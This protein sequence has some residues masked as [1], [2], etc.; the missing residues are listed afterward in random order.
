MAE[1][2]SASILALLGGCA[3]TAHPD[4]TGVWQVADPELVKRP[5]VYATEADYMPE[6]WSNLQDYRKNWEARSDDPVSVCVK[7]GMP[8]VM[9]ARA[10]TY[11]MDIFQAASRIT[12]LMEYMDNHR[13]IHLDHTSIPAT[14]TPSNNGYSVGHWDGDALV[15][16]TTMLKARSPVGPIQR[17]D[18]A[19]FTERW[20]MR[21]DPTL[22]KII[23]IDIT[24]YDP[25]TFR[26]PVE[27][28]QVLKPADAG[29][30]LNEYACADS[31][32]EDHVARHRA[33]SDATN[34]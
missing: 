6:A 5:D 2:L 17:S 28:H 8:H 31:L 16:E 33:E 15:I 29:T 1:L 30:V 11:V 21:N 4:F 26:H 27:S 14:I 23:N 22:G 3:T 9:T 7:Y 18:Q 32:W 20:T 25:V 34:Q 10:R 13:L 19:R 12:V 24:T